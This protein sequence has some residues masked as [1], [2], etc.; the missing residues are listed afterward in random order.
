MYLSTPS[1]FKATETDKGVKITFKAVEG[2]E[3]YRIYRKAVGD[4]SWHSLGEVTINSYTDNTIKEN[5]TYIYTARAING[6]TLSNYQKNPVNYRIGKKGNI[7]ENE[8]II[9]SVLKDATSKK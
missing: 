8:Q 7:S 4:K 1:L 6:K 9:N 2:A 3:K 5:V